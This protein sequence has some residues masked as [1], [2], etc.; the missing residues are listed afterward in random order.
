MQLIEKYFGD[1]SP[2]QKN[3]FE[4]LGKLYGEWNE[5]VNVISR[6]DVDHLYERHVLHSLGI[7]AICQFKERTRILDIGTGGGF[8]GIPLAILFP[9]CT[10]Y[11]VDSIGKKIMVVNE[12]INALGLKNIKA[13][14]I[15][16]EKVKGQF[17][18][19]VSRA[20]TRLAKFMPW[21]HGK[22][23]KKGFND[24]PNGIFYLKGGDLDEELSELS[25]GKVI[26]IYD[27]KDC[28]EEEFFETKRVVH[29]F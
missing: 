2:Q 23:I 13:E 15:R 29:V 22:L 27:L 11:C 10:F 4:Q 18:F 1:L 28:F 12:I 14:Q 24:R 17:D 5:K 19:V 9:E 8:P 20:V 26:H 3:Q 6:K 7:A 25:K 21:T 16:A